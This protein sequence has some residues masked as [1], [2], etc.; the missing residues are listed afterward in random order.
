MLPLFPIL[1]KLAEVEKI[2]E[3]KSKTQQSSNLGNL[4]DRFCLHEKIIH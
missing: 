3:M 1:E 2:Q 4:K